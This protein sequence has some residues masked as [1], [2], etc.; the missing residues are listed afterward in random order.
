M[1]RIGNFLVELLSTVIKASHHQVR[2]L[3]SLD[4]KVNRIMSTQDQLASDLAAVSSQVAKIGTETGT[5]VA[6]VAELE[7]A[8][9]SGGTTTPA[10]DAALAALKAQ[11]Q[12]VDDL[13]ADAAPTP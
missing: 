3:Q 11:V 10:V 9:A 2:L 6:K 8:L 7:A 5:L 13:V 1:S 4:Q 12:V